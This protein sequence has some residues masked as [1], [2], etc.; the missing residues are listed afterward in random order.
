[1]SVGSSMEIKNYTT[2]GD[3]YV[4]YDKDNVCKL[5]ERDRLY[6]LSVIS[7]LKSKQLILKRYRRDAYILTY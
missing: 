7:L 3:Y 1:M 5:V 4:F 6:G 2:K